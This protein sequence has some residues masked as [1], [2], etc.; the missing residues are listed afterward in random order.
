MGDVDLT[1]LLRGGPL[2]PAT[3]ENL[4]TIDRAELREVLG[5]YLS[6]E[7][8]DALESRIDALIASG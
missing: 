1:E 4:K 2:D 3:I 5:K 6:D 8:L 7:E